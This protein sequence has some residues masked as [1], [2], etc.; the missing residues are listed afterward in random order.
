MEKQLNAQRQMKERGRE[1]RNTLEE[2]VKKVEKKEL[3]YSHP[4]QAQ[5]FV[6]GKS[7]E[8]CQKDISAKQ[9]DEGFRRQ[10]LG[11]K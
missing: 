8:R 9:S 3:G 5:V 1:Y 11:R 7:E 4:I 10:A 6:V 2:N